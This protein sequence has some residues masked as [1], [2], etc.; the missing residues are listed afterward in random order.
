MNQNNLNWNICISLRR[1]GE[2]TDDVIAQKGRRGLSILVYR[3]HSKQELS[4]KGVR[5]DHY[6]LVAFLCCQMN[7]AIL[8]RRLFSA[9]I[10]RIYI[11][12]SLTPLVEFRDPN[13]LKIAYVGFGSYKESLAR[14]FYDCRGE[15]AY[16]P[17]QL[18]PRC[19]ETSTQTKTTNQNFVPIESN[20]IDDSDDLLNLPVFIAGKQD[21]HILVSS[22]N[23]SV[24]KIRNG[25]EIGGFWCDAINVMDLRVKIRF[26]FTVVGDRVNR[27]VVIHSIHNG[28]MQTLADVRRGDIFLRN[29]T[30]NTLIKISK[31]KGNVVRHN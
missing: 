7:Y 27:R 6:G 12:H 18:V 24:D 30:L 1:L 25:Y 3:W 14:F 17:E 10:I 28:N 29:E 8:V 20:K 23:S 19:E 4:I 11:E 15:E 16:T 21:A 26:I 13:P 5:W 9:G 22:D 2:Q 31:C